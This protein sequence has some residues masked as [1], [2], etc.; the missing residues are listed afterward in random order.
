MDQLI[1]ILDIRVAILTPGAN[2]V[3]AYIAGAVPHASPQGN[4]K[5]S[6]YTTAQM[7]VDHPLRAYM[8]ID[9]ELEKDS[10]YQAEA[11]AALNQ[12]GLVVCI[13]AYMTDTM[14]Q[15]ADFILPMAPFGECAG[16]YTNYAGTNQ[17]FSAASQPHEQSKPAWKIVRALA[18]F[19]EL[20]NFEYQ[21]VHQVRNEL[22]GLLPELPLAQTVSLPRITASSNELLARLVWPIYSEDGLVRRSAALAQ[23]PQQ[24]TA[25]FQLNDQ[26]A[27]QLGF[28]DGDS[29]CLRQGKHKTILQLKVEPRLAKGVLVIP[30]GI[31]QTQGLAHPL[32]SIDLQKEC[33]GE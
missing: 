31:E 30:A 29:L 10:V 14:R 20:P 19:L 7:L 11:L 28:V 15:Y 1:H 5:S 18:G 4:V 16:S 33:V 9:V 25:H 13:N 27:Q 2:S 22:Y 32:S 21:T 3:G 6:G 17:S 12:A 24:V 26:T 8:L 23:A